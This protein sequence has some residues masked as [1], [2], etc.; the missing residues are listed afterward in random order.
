MKRMKRILILSAACAALQTSCSTSISTA[1]HNPTCTQISDPVMN[2]VMVHGFLQKGH[3]FKPLRKRLEKRNVRCLTARL[4]PSDGRSGICTLAGDL[5]QQ[6]ED[7]F[8]PDEE[9]AIVG[10]SM[11][12]LVSR[13]YLQNLGGAERC[14][15]LITVSSPHN[16]TIT[17]YLYPGKGTEQMRPNSEFLTELDRTTEKLGD[18]PVTSYRTPMDLVVLPTTSSVWDRAENRKHYAPLH[19]MMLAIPSVLGDIEERLLGDL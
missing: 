2:V 10:Y 9:F 16:G 19:P 15:Q 4:S 12:G 18:M 8:G 7:H 1:K 6:I 17:A 13:Y 14:N 5:K 3:S 11:G